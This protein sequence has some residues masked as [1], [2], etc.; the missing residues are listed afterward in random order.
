MLLKMLNMDPY[1]IEWMCR[2]LGHTTE[3]HKAYYRHM[4]GF[5]ERVQL[6]KLFMIQDMNLTSKFKG[7]KLEEIDISG[8]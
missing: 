7:K 6:S 2:H 1:Q 5:V 4:S 3:V 8:W